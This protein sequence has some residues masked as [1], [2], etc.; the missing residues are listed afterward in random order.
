MSCWPKPQK[1][2]C[3]GIAASGWEQM[4]RTT[5]MRRSK[6][7]SAAAR[8]GPSPAR[9]SS[10][11]F[12]GWPR[13]GNGNRHPSTATRRFFHSPTVLESKAGRFNQTLSALFVDDARIMGASA[14]FLPM[15]RK[16]S[17]PLFGQTISKKC[18]RLIWRSIPGCAAASNTG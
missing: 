15:K 16:G 2:S 17:A 18:P 9:R 7:R 10:G 6:R 3:I 4:E 5:A 13:G 11:Y 14:G 8:L 12:P 1:T